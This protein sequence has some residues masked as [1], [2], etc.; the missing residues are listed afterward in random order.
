MRCLIVVLVF[1][2]VFALA[3]CS[4]GANTQSTSTQSPPSISIADTSLAEGDS[5]TSA[6]NFTVTLSRS[7][8]ATISVAYSTSDVT[9]TAGNDYISTSGTLTIASGNTVGTITVDVLGDTLNEPDETFTVTLRDA[10]GATIAGSMATAT[11][12]NDDAVAA[13]GLD[14]RPDNQTCVA[15]QR[16]VAVTSVAAEEAFPGISFAGP[17]KLLMEPGVNRRWFILLKSGQIEVLDADNPTPGSAYL[18]ISGAVNTAGEGGLLGMA[19]HP[20]YPATPH[21]FISYTRDTSPMRSVFSRVILDDVISPGAIGAGSEEQVILEVNQ[22]FST[23]NGGDI[24]FGPDGLL[25][26]GL[27]D[28]GSA[29]DPNERAQDTTYLLGSFLRIDVTGPGVSHPA[30]PY[31]IPSDNPFADQPKCGPAGNANSCPEIYAWG[32]RNPW[33]WSFDAVTGALWAGDVGQGAREEVDIIRLGRNYGWDCREGFSEFADDQPSDCNGIYEDPVHDYPRG[34]G[35]SITGGMVYRGT[36]IGGRV[37]E[38]V[39]ADYGSG[40]IWALRSDGQGGYINEQLLDEPG[41]PVAFA[42]DADGELYFANINNGRIYKLVP[43]AGGNTGGAIPDLLSDSGCV[44]P[45]DVTAPYAGLLPYDVNAAFWSDGAVKSRYIGLPNGTTMTINAEDDWGF[46]AGTVIVKNFRLGGNL[47]ETRHL[48]RHPDGVWAGYTYEWNAEQT[49]ATRVIGGKTVTIG[50]Q[51]W[52]FPSGAQCEQCHTA[53]A[54]IALGPET[55]QM[56]RDITYPSSGRSDN[57]LETID[58]I[59]MFSSP[60]AGTPDSLPRLANPLDDSADLDDRARAYLH[61]NCSNC[62]R[63]GG[64]TPVDIDLRYD[65]ALQNTGA[66]ETVPQAGMLGIMNASIIAAG[67]AARSTLVA[68]MN[69]RGD[70]VSMPPLGSTVVDDEG[71]TLIQ[72]W[73]NALAGC[74]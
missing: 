8:T 55:A 52:V 57:Q 61:T 3:A 69:R 17:T 28:G 22:D 58:H 59:M 42:A 38:Y 72:D 16:P 54:G 23:H 41:G 19:F 49:E 13:F 37:G 68:R 51:A 64:G 67:D 43:G 46:P 11:I 33:R 25:Y 53:A 30:N 56:N 14:N 70:N 73:V 6:L 31:D 34:E 71:V 48:M 24:A 32:M 65:V 36:A 27:G 15:P 21:I 40:R 66:C 26:I 9:A 1:A 18:D 29:G 7:S 50:G 47:V 35:N 62:H 45:S 60:L 4:G 10:T 2:L 12:Q 63:P 20:G 39:Y 44:D 5:G 74:Q